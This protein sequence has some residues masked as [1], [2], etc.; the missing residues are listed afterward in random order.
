MA[1]QVQ[2]L[3]AEFNGD[4]PTSAI[5][6]CEIRV[7]DDTDENEP[8]L[9]ARFNFIN[10][11]FS[12]VDSESIQRYRGRRLRGRTDMIRYACDVMDSY[13]GSVKEG[14]GDCKKSY[15]KKDAEGN[16]ISYKEQ[17]FG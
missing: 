13:V 14:F 16:V 12:Q 11:V 10:G 9:F 3:R 17:Y 1:L 4:Q 15:T 8:Q 7:W 5:N 2:K 6:N